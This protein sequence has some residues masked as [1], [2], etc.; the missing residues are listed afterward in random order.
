MSRYQK[1]MCGVCSGTGL[2]WYSD[3]PTKCMYCKGIGFKMTEQQVRR[4]NAW[5]LINNFYVRH[6]E[7]IW[8]WAFAAGIAVAWAYDKF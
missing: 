6:S 1:V 2:H 4:W 5:A 8:G 7:G 3:P